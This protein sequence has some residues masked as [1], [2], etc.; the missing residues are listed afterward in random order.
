MSSSILPFPPFLTFGRRRTISSFIILLRHVIP[1]S[2]KHSASTS[3]ETLHHRPPL[4]LISLRK[5]LLKEI[6]ALVLTVLFTVLQNVPLDLLVDLVPIFLHL[7][8]RRINDLLFGSSLGNADAVSSEKSPIFAWFC[9]L[10][11]DFNTVQSVKNF[12]SDWNYRP[13]E[14]QIQMIGFFI[15]NGEVDGDPIFFKFHLQVLFLFHDMR[16]LNA[17]LR[18]GLIPRVDELGAQQLGLIDVLPP[19][20]HHRTVL[21]CISTGNFYPLQQLCAHVIK[22]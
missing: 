9:L 5:N 18:G 4:L 22:V 11:H 21:K 20:F 2:G 12:R 13:K 16:D 8:A 10:H 19:Q 14:N 17:N 1:V 7:W 15:E 6:H 3:L